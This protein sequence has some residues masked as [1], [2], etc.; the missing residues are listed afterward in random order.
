MG[1]P[2]PQAQ[3]PTPHR[4]PRPAEPPHRPVEPA[5][6]SKPPRAGP[7]RACTPRASLPPGV[8]RHFL[9]GDRLLRGADERANIGGGVRGV[10]ARRGGAWRWGKEV[11]E[12]TGSQAQTLRLLSVHIHKRCISSSCQ[13]CHWFL[14]LFYKAAISD[15]I[16]LTGI[17]SAFRAYS[18]RIRSELSKYSKQYEHTRTRSHNG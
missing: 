7:G 4:S 18:D 16:S 15:Q 5:I 8:L 3:H 6:L 10:A 12:R 14:L 2:H 9:H 17:S 1:H 11:S 13:F